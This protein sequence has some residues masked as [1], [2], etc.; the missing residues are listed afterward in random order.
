MAK[1]IFKNAERYQKCKKM[2]TPVF[3][4]IIPIYNVER[5]L[6]K[7]VQS[8]INQTYSDIEIILVDD[9]SP[10]NCPAMCDEYAKR[11][12]RIK[13]IHKENGGLSDARNKGL[14]AAT[15]KYV[16]FVD[17][18]DY[19]EL[20]TCESL[21]P[22][23]EK[24][25]DIISGN[26]IA[27]GANK[28]LTQKVEPKVCYTGKEYLKV[29][30]ERGSMPV[31]AWLYAYRRNFLKENDL[32]F[33]YGI[34]H[35]DEQFT[36]RAFLKADKV[37]NSQVSFY[38]YIIRENSITTNKNLS[39]NILD[40][41]ETCL[42][43]ETIYFDVN[44]E[45]LEKLLKDSLVMKYL[46]LFQDGKGYQYGKEY[47]PKYF[48]RRNAYLKRTKLKAML[49]QLSPK[50]YWHINNLEKRLQGR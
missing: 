1:C 24:D 25:Y 39:K 22:F 3:S 40:L 17:S 50:V 21:L 35:E 31:A 5:Q 43:L 41:Y 26:G 6:D 8:I 32:S 16:M 46:S 44:D 49:F 33:K 45:K 4:V 15:G 29:A 20:S 42:E 19:I 23:A 28:K 18:D 38:H 34:T 7:C 47:A 37:I 10:D 36:P 9:G 2:N 12:K 13:V 14:K 11:D 48:V 30:L 27:E